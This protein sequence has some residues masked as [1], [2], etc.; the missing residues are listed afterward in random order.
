[1]LSPALSATLIQSTGDPREGI[2]SGALAAAPAGNS[3]AGNLPSS[4]TTSVRRVLLLVV[5]SSVASLD[6]AITAF[7]MTRHGVDELHV[8]VSADAEVAARD[9]M[10]AWLKKS[11]AFARM[12]RTAGIDR[13]RLL[14]GT[15]AL[16][17]VDVK[18]A[19]GIG[20]DLANGLLDIVREICTA[21]TDLTIIVPQQAGAMAVAAHAALQIGGRP[22]DRF[23]LLAEPSAS[24]RAT[25]ARLRPSS[26]PQPRTT[27]RLMEFPVVLEERTSVVSYQELAV[28]R[29]RARRRLADPSPMIISPRRRT[30]TIDGTAIRLPRLAFY[31]VWATARCAPR[32]LPTRALYGNFDVDRNGRLT[33]TA[34]A[35]EQPRTEAAVRQLEQLFV[36]LFPASADEFA[37]VLKRACGASPGLPGTMSRINAALKREL[38]I[39]A[40]PYTIVSERGSDGY[41]FKSP[42]RVRFES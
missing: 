21:R 14:L 17:V 34:D 7:V 28:E 42:I 25:L 1:M 35:D 26:R 31:W 11:S 15:R 30:V 32:L 13:H 16:R 37:L 9:A 40:D 33:I 38:G 8:V 29:Q 4:L 20:W 24:E 10:C 19:G 12:C 23:Y 39:A 18:L 6:D 5:G 41:R 22:R 3:D 2:H 36:T 27:P